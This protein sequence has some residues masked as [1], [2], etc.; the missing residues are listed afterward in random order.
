MTTHL[1]RFLLLVMNISYL[2]AF[3]EAS[4]FYAAN[5]LLH[6][7]LG[8]F[9]LLFAVP[10]AKRL[11]RGGLTPLLWWM[12][13]MALGATALTGLALVAL[14]NLRPMRPLLLAHVAVAVGGAPAVASAV[15]RA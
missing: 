3:A 12:A 4:V 11:L 7:V 1:G 2:A 9:L 14:G 13:G 10:E 6:V 8:I 5:V 15:P